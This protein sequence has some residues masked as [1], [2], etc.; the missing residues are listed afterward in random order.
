M[1]PSMIV[2][3]TLVADP[4]K[5]VTNTPAT[6]LALTNLAYC[7]HADLHGFTIPDPPPPK[8]EGSGFATGKLRRSSKEAN[9]PKL[10][11]SGDPPSKEAETHHQSR[12]PPPI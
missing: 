4:G 6:D 12:N 10:E 9:S 1:N 3:N 11:G 5:I 8:L 2:M 7:L